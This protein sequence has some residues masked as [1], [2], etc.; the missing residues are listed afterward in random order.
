MAASAAAAGSCPSF[1]PSFAVV[2][3]FL[4]RYGAALNLP[5]LTFPQLEGYLLETSTV[6]QVLV[7]L[8]VK[9]LRKIGK[10]V[11]VD[12]WEKYLIKVCQE[13]NSTWAWELEKKGY[14]EM[15]VECKTGILKYLCECQF[16]D[17]IK[18][19]AAINEEDPDK[20]RLQPIG[21]D[22]DGLM[23]WY[24]LDQ[25]HN[26]RVYVEEQDDLD[27]SSWKCI[28]RT[29]NDLMETLAQL[30][31][32]LDPSLV[33]KK[34][35][36]EGSTSTS[37]NPEDEEQKKEELE[38]NAIKTE[39]PVDTKSEDEHGNLTKD[40][41]CFTSPD[42]QS[43]GKSP[44]K[45]SKE[46][47]TDNEA[48]PMECTENGKK[49]E[50]LNETE[51]NEEKPIIDN[52]VKTITGAIKE[53]PKAELKQDK[54]ADPLT[55]IEKPEVPTKTESPMEAKI[56]MAEDGQKAVKSDQQAKIPLKKREM[57]LSDDFDSNNGASIPIR[58]ASP[59]PAK[60]L[61]KEDGEAQEELTS[62]SSLG[63]SL[64]ETEHS[65]VNT[66][67]R[68][69][70]ENGNGSEAKGEVLDRS[71]HRAQLKGEVDHAVSEEETGMSGDITAAATEL[72]KGVEKDKNE[73]EEEDRKEKKKAVDDTD[74]TTELGKDNEEVKKSEEKKTKLMEGEKDKENVDEEKER[75][76]SLE[77]K[78]KKKSA[79][80]EEDGK[81][82][83]ECNIEEE[84]E[85][86]EKKQV[87][88]EV[89]GKKKEEEKKE[90][91]KAELVKSVSDQPAKS[92]GMKGSM[93]ALEDSPS[94]KAEKSCA[95]LASAV[96]ERSNDEQNVVELESSALT[97]VEDKEG[98]REKG[99]VSSEQQEM[100][101]D[102]LQKDTKKPSELS[103]MDCS[104]P[105]VEEPAV[106]DNQAEKKV[107]EDGTEED[108]DS[109]TTEEESMV[110]KKKEERGK[111][112]QSSRKKVASPE[113][114]KVDEKAEYIEKEVVGSEEM[115]K[116]EDIETSLKGLEDESKQEGGVDAETV[117]ENKD[118]EEDLET[119]KLTTRA[120]KE[121]VRKKGRVHGHQKKGTAKRD[122]DVQP[123]LPPPVHPR[124]AE[125]QKEERKPDSESDNAE[126]RSL[127]RSPRICRPSAKL[128]EI[129]DMKMEKKQASLLAEH[130]KKDSNDE[131]EVKPVQ[132][133]RQETPAESDNQPKSTKG[134]RQ[135]RARWSNIRRRKIKDSS[136]ED[137]EEDEEYEEVDDDNSDEDYKVE[138][139]R[140]R[141]NRNRNRND[142]E[143]SS[144]SDGLPPNEDPCKHCGLPNHP[145][146]I[147][148]CDSCDSGY[149]TACLR[150]P[151]MI[152]PDGEWF[153]PPCQHKQLCDKLEEELQKLDAALK[154]KERAVRRKER[155]VYVGISV[156]NIIPPPQVE[157]QEEKVIEEEEEEEE[158]E[159]KEKPKSWNFGRRSRRRRK[160]ISYRFDEFDEAIEEAIEEDIKEAEGGGTGRGKDMANITGHRGKDI[161]TI[162]K[163]EGKENGQPPRLKPAARKRKRRRLNDLDSDSA[164][165]EE[166]SEEEFRLSESS[167][168]EEFAVSDNYVESDAEVNSFN[169]SDFG[170]SGD[171]PC[172]NVWSKKQKKSSLTRA[173]RQRKPHRKRGY[174]DDEE[175]EET[176]EDEEE[177]EMVTEESS[178]F[179]DSE[180][181]L[182]RRRSSR[183]LKKQVNYCET[184]DSDGSQAATNRDK[185]K[186]TH[187]R[188]L[189]SSDSEG[190]FCLDDDEE[191]KD[192]KRRARRDTFAER[193]FRQRRRL[194]TLKRRR[195]S[196]EDDDDDSDESE[197]EERPV[198]KRLNRI[199]SDEEEEEEQA[200]S[201]MGR[202][203]EGLRKAHRMA[204]EEEESPLDYNLVELPSANG[205]SPMKGL[206]GFISS[207]PGGLQGGPK[208]SGVS[209]ASLA[210]NGLVSQE[211]APQDE[212]EDDLLGVTDLVDYVCNSEQL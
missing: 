28:V 150:P 83:N 209:A 137:E 69:P 204:S 125:I 91:T 59:T 159:E 30:K 84:E 85:H 183:S 109:K 92:T 49:M 212:E 138:N 131:E 148:L 93:A 33:T 197:E 22:K 43:E 132:K 168:E 126:G 143:T 96:K 40:T 118:V 186:S 136:E 157:V 135:R 146:L 142:S 78:E 124:K 151:L 152:I 153:C 67:V 130:E 172:L 9:L 64:K 2:C 32:Q 23:Y 20:M 15:T 169:D 113:V 101:A 145:E 54:C 205:Q 174:S 185:Q 14:L 11:S 18:F 163:E 72:N 99:E 110:L 164:P 41:G 24:Q 97:S 199:D 104:K 75:N 121:S 26:I 210:P 29:R 108:P 134:R 66:E 182:R 139:D 52:K 4:E 10:F 206:E 193:D 156:E 102:K 175:V 128:A 55:V 86:K 105:S 13:F 192:K 167:E 171:G 112:R 7:D 117:D 81:N 71:S 95:S 189:S 178:D 133:K 34:E 201:L 149:H 119:S 36:E 25:D 1:C 90:I 89:E 51:N 74:K 203:D 211:M 160:H 8:H 176:E 207:R 115:R 38:G 106:L 195:A 48:V 62:S 47:T 98:L 73:K 198:R 111:E 191:E 188:R 45:D 35:L 76:K 202:E 161:S 63:E 123:K 58:N 42:S 165:E 94:E 179:S 50:V 88:E 100:D 39:D 166:E 158:E 107:V 16:D 57:K 70:A 37:P 184:S 127:R 173:T 154:K 5:E 103:L 46:V 114:E 180:L 77:D 162:M 27:G 190:S 79:E 3:S 170:S 147:L 21:R 31:T 56:K 177:E 129:Q 155:L 61:P 60:N 194:L 122:E 116:T 120:S 141:R 82:T 181:D 65:P 144:S 44:V 208:F 140:K 53:E 87:V 12:K 200:K 19:K 80:E 187:R 17:N 196:E 68:T 6:P